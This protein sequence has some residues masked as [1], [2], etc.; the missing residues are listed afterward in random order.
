M[1]W[2]KTGKVQEYWPHD[3]TMGRHGKGGGGE[4]GTLTMEGV[5]EEI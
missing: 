2:W 1:D 5:R 4:E 3:W